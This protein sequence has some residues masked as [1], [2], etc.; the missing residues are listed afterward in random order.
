M[1][2]HHHQQAFVATKLKNKKHHNHRHLAQDDHPYRKNAWTE[3][4]M[5]DTHTVEYE[6]ETAKQLST[7][8]TDN[9]QHKVERNW[10]NFPMGDF[11]RTRS[12]A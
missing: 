3:Q 4:Q 1:K 9:Y 11:E 12:H 6:A 7:P 10:N 2:H 8:R 5:G